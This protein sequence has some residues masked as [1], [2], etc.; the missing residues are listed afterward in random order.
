MPVYN[1]EDCIAQVIQSWLATLSR[2][3]T[4]FVV[5]VLNDGSTDGTQRALDGF[6]G[7]AR[8]QVVHKANSGHG[9]TI[10]QGYRQAVALAEWVF[11]VDSDDELESRHF[12]QLWR[13]RREYDAVFGIR[14]RRR[15]SMGRRVISCCSRLMVKGLFGSK[16]ADVN[17]PYRLM[18]AEL[19]APVVAAIPDDTFAPNT[20]IAG[21]FSR[22]GARVHNLPI[23]HRERQTG[24]V[25]IAKWRLWKAALLSARQVWRCRRITAEAPARTAT[26]AGGQ[27]DL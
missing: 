13:L 14:L 1:E 25:S 23:P 21:A 17:V 4:R 11:Q 6:A 8:V 10:L 24:E 27:G 18:R 16:V 7:D 2:L 22:G 19:L 12:S 5:I 9:P 15:Q 26:A 3:E 20:I